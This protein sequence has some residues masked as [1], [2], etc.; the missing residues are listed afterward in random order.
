MARWRRKTGTH[1]FSRIPDEPPERLLV[2]A[3]AA[4]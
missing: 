4:P 1:G 3:V 2:H